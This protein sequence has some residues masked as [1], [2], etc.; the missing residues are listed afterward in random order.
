MIEQVLLNLLQ[1]AEQAFVDKSA[2]KDS[3]NSQARVTI[4]AFLNLRG[5]VVIDVGNN[6]PIIPEEIAKEVF[7]PF[8]TTKIEGSGVGLALSRQIMLAHQG[9]ILLRN[10]NDITTRADTENEVKRNDSKGVTFSLTF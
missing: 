1:N 3:I 2:N 7:V 8:Y 9:S 6:G 4:H 5:K 10:N